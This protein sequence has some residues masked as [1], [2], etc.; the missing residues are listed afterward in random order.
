METISIEPPHTVHTAL[1]FLTS[2]VKSVVNM[3][4]E[5]HQGKHWTKVSL[6]QILLHPW[7]QPLGVPGCHRSATL[8]PGHSLDVLSSPMPC[9]AVPLKWVLHT[10]ELRLLFLAKAQPLL[11]L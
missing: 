10:S 7:L 11:K 3:Q 1:S 6:T 2:V 5:E 9:A 8:H 4:A